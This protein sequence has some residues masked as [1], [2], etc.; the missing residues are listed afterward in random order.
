MPPGQIG[1][2]RA[3]AKNQGFGFAVKPS[4]LRTSVLERVSRDFSDA[5][6][7]RHGRL[8]WSDLAVATALTIVLGLA[9]QLIL[10]IID[11]ATAVL[12]G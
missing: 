2:K 8:L 4:L 3:R 11:Q 7:L 12:A 9:P 6:G 10:G 1:A 5:P